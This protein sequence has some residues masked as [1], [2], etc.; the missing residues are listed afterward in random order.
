MREAFAESWQELKHLEGQ[1]AA[2]EGDVWLSRKLK[3][4]AKH[5]RPFD[6]LYKTT[7]AKEEIPG[8]QDP[9]D[10]AM[11][12]GFWKFTPSSSSESNG[13]HRLF[14]LVDE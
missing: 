4:V 9:S 7:A 6:S 12:S 8:T 10:L 3:T 5:W 2:G 13:A 1:S 14:S 11:T